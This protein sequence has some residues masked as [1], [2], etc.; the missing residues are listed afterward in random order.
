MAKLKPKRKQPRKK[1]LNRQQ[2]E[3]QL[4]RYGRLLD[5]W[6]AKMVTAANQ[7]AKYRSKTAYYQKRLTEMDASM[8]LELERLRAEAEQA[9]DRPLRVIDL[10]RPS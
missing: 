5:A 3:Q 9:A 4:T 7:V 1:A 10:G 6:V 2:A 8:T